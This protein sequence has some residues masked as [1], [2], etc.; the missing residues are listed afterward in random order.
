MIGQARVLRQSD[1]DFEIP[2]S[3]E[4]CLISSFD[5]PGRGVYRLSEIFGD[6]R[7][8]SGLFPIMSVGDFGDIGRNNAFVS[9]VSG[10]VDVLDRNEPA[11]LTLYAKVQQVNG[12][13]GSV[14]LYDSLVDFGPKLVLVDDELDE[15]DEEDE[16]EQFS[17]V[18][19]G[20]ER[21]SGRPSEVAWG[22]F[23]T[24]MT[25]GKRLSQVLA[26]EDDRRL[27]D[28]LGRI[29]SGMGREPRRIVKTPD[30]TMRRG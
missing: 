7:D 27:S 5:A 17:G 19:D 15:L 24:S 29:A 21:D 18:E 20:D 2:P 25:R 28:L 16:E 11:K 23:L 3:A 8:T 4:L 30:L 26:E 22:D 12:V 14:L 6:V 13:N 1:K 9:C 10:L